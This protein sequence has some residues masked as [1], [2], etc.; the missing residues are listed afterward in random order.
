MI[1][2]FAASTVLCILLVPGLVRADTVVLS[3]GDRLTGSIESLEDGNLVLGSPLLGSVRIGW[4]DI[5][6]IES[7]STFSVLTMD[8]DRLEGRLSRTGDSIAVS[9]EGE[10]AQ[11]MDSP[12]VARIARGARKRGAASLL[13]NL[14]GS[15]DIGYSLA[16]GNQNQMQ[17][18]LGARASYQSA[19]YEFSGRL[20]SLFARQDG[21]RSQSRHALNTRLDRFVNARTFV[22]GL[23][24]FERNERRRLNLRTRLGGGFGWRVQASRK[25]DF[26]VLGGFAFVH[27]IYREQARRRTGEG[28]LGIEWEA[29][30]LR[31]VVVSTHLTLHPDLLDRSNIRAELDSAL[32]VPI[33]G[34]FTYSLRLFDRYATKP[35]AGVERNDYGLVSGIGVTF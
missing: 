4:S 8:G 28:F 12:A 24:G 20:D 9:P 10:P 2:R 32:R 34:R 13:R 21:A 15:A 17:S 35:A 16:R 18:S 22:Y 3:N 7:E 1:A 30:L 27:E 33:A 25:S 14:D 6:S 19:E 11:R 31:D 29:T 26:A 5:E 23:T